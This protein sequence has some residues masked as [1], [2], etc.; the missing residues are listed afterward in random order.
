MVEKQILFL[1]QRQVGQDTCGQRGTESEVTT[2]I[3]E[4][5]S[6]IAGIRILVSKLQISCPCHIKEART[7]RQESA[8]NSPTHSTNL[9][10]ATE[11]DK[12]RFSLCTTEFHH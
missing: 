7:P 3:S 9:T 1:W 4:F 11:P 6:G 12:C 10:E 2:Q 8:S 5:R